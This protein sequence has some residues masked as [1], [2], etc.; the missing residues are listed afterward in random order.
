[1]STRVRQAERV[2]VTDFDGCQALTVYERIDGATYVTYVY[3]YDGYL[4]ELYCAE[5]ARLQKDAGEKIMPA[6]SIRFSVAGDL[7]T[8][9]VDGNRILLQLRGKEGEVP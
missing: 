6:E 3:C 5:N 8:A 4:R 7:L 2:A 1:M 9:T